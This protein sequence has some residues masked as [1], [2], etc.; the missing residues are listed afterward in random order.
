MPTIGNFHTQY[1]A[2]SDTAVPGAPGL[3]RP[4]YPPWQSGSIIVL[5]VGFGG[6]LPY[7]ERFVT[8][9]ARMWRFMGRMWTLTPAQC[10]V[11]DRVLHTFEHPAY[12][13]AGKTV[14]KTA[15]TL[16]FN[17]PEAWQELG[18][19]LK[20]NPG[21]AENTFRHLESCR[22]LHLNLVGSTLT[23]PQAHLMV[24]LAYQEFAAMGR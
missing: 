15:T 18:K 11:L 10:L 7:W 1:W 8:W 13:M 20:R 3:G 6:L 2:S 17:R 16:G 21:E 24:E 5:G 22:L 14:R 23:N 19:A 9:C 4:G 12:P